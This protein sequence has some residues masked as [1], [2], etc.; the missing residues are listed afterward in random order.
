MKKI[1]ISRRKGETQAV[2]FN[3]GEFESYFIERDNEPPKFVGSI[4]LAQ[5][6]KILQGMQAAFIDIGRDK[7]AFLQYG[8]KN[9]RE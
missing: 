8:N 4:F 7:N 9:L 5:V 2:I 6:E 1:L 3:D